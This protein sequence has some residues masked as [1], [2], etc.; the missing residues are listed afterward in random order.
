MQML[1]VL[2]SLLLNIVD[3][4][5]SGSCA[6]DDES[7]EELVN[8][9]RT[10]TRRDNQW[11]KYQAYTFLGISRAEFDRRVKAG[12]IPKGKKIAGFKELFWSEKEIRAL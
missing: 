5:D 7:C 2:K 10:Y 6:L 9:L 11:S 4:I 12:K 8:T 3:D 1:D